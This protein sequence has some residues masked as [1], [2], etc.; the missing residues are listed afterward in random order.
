MKKTGLPFR[1]LPLV[2][3]SLALTPALRAEEP[4][5]PELRFNGYV[6]ADFSG[7]LRNGAAN[8]GLEADL[9]TTAVLGPRLN[10]VLY[11]TM[12]DGVVP[13]QGSGATWAPV[14][15]D[16]AALNW[17]YT[18]ALTLHVGDLINGAGYFNYYLNKR[19][20]VVVGEHAVRG[21]G[22]TWKGLYAATG[23]ASVNSWSTFVKYD[24]AIGP[25]ATLTPAIKQTLV[26]GASPV[27]GGL[28][29]VASFGEYALKADA[30]VNYWSGNY[31]PGYTVLV[32][33][34]WSS[35]RY[36]VTGSVF[37]NEKGS[38]PAP[39][40]P[41]TTLPSPNADSV[42]NLLRGGRATFD[43]F[44]VYVEPGMSLNKTVSVGLP[45]EYHIPSLDADV[46]N[47]F[48]A[49]PTLYVY[50][51]AGVEWWIWAQGVFPVAGGNPDLY[52]GSELIFRF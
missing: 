1:L 3:A 44:F 28:S 24:Y 23:A 46:G 17:A 50:P 40:V 15:F 52:A 11:T 45:L 18:D 21:V 6:D 27:E 35:G 30:A 19:A 47:A 26:S 22:A 36:S 37:Y 20:A 51:G 43:D 8:T 13:A 25:N 5:K 29:Y 14:R 12:T 42:S 34:S 9:T 33:P 39:N 4:A 49:V 32:E 16:G 31:D 7:D 2:V 38:K 41:A 48:W 10:A